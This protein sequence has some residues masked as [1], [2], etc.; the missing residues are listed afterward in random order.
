MLCLP[1]ICCSNPMELPFNGFYGVL[2]MGSVDNH[3]KYYHSIEANTGPVLLG[4]PPPQTKDFRISNNN[5][6]KLSDFAVTGG[7]CLGYSQTVLAGMLLGIEARANWQNLTTESLTLIGTNQT[8]FFNTQ[9]AIEQNQDYALLGKLGYLIGINTQL[10]GLLG[11]QWGHFRLQ[12]YTTFQE[13]EAGAGVIFTDNDLIQVG[14][15]KW[16][17]FLGLGIEQWLGHHTTIGIEYHF[18]HYGKLYFPRQNTTLV[19]DNGAALPDSRFTD[20]SIFKVN[21]QATLFKIAYYL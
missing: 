12:S 17:T 4:S 16:G 9:A 11:A 2:H 21:A 3:I 7:L 15:H 13:V 18:S 5:P 19:L 10:Y 14:V 20:D 6:S 1:E 8:P